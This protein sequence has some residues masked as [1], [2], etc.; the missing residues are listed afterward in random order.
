MRRLVDILGSAV[1]LAMLALPFAAIALAI[2]LNSKGP[3]F[4]RQERAGK[5]GKPFLIWKFRTMVNGAADMG[6][7]N[8]VAQADPRITKVGSVLARTCSR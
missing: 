6:L 2:R 5:D 7:G 1:G 8:T 4:F 3:V